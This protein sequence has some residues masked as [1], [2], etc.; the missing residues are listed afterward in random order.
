MNKTKRIL[1]ITITIFTVL[2]YFPLLGTVNIAQAALL[3]AGP[4][5]TLNGFPVWYQDNNGVAIQ[6]CLGINPDGTGLPDPLC[7][8]PGAGEE[9]NFDPLLPISF[10][11]NFPG[12]AFWWLAEIVENGVGQPDAEGGTGRLKFRYA[13]E[14]AFTVENPTPNE[15]ILFLRVNLM[16]ISHLVPGANYLVTHPFGQFTVHAGDALLPDGLPNPAAGVADDGKFLRIE[17]GAFAP[18]ITPLTAASILP[19]TETNIGSFLRM[20]NP[21]PPA[22]YLGDG[23][24]IGTITSGPNGNFLEIAGPN[25]DVGNIDGDGNPNKLHLID[26]WMVSGKIAVI[27]TVA[28]AIASVTPAEVAVDAAGNAPTNTVISANITDDLGARVTTID[29]SV[30]SNDF[31][32]VLNGIQEVP[33]TVSA[34]TGSGAFM[35]D[36]VANTLNF[37]ISY[38]GLQGGAETAAHI[39]GP[40]IAG[41]NAL[42][43]FDLPFGASKIGA[44][45]YPENLEADILAGRMYINIHTT[46]F[47]NGEIRGQILRTPNIQNMIM[48]AGT[49]TNGTW[50]IIIPSIPGLGTYILPISTSDGS[51]VTNFVFELSAVNPAPI[52]NADTATIGVN[53]GETAT[54]DVLA[55]DT[56]SNGNLPLSL[57]SVQNISAGTATINGNRV[58]ITTPNNVFAGEITAQYTVADSLGATS[59]GNITVTVVRSVFTTITVT[60]NP[61]T[62]PLSGNRQLNA[63][64]KDQFG[65]P[66]SSQPAITW[67]SSNNQVATVSGTGLVNGAALG[68]TQITAASGA[69][70]AV[71]NV[72]VTSGPVCETTADFDLSGAISN[73]EILNHVRAWK[74]GTVLNLEI[75]NAIRFWKTGTGC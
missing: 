26:R 74:A 38:S 7:V 57:V 52:A 32:T 19:A 48:N 65:T 14:A 24:A 30:L 36:T 37:N 15:Q 25:I 12:E 1:S 55:N 16:P 8:L 4:I 40:A 72:T 47:P 49:V 23:L 18:P 43:V 10:P 64:A 20:V 34:G 35:I 39:H 60:P 6:L 27:D 21:A 28:P 17:D 68:N 67:T 3:Q 33:A 69:I 73:L 56:D 22:G 42:P 9:P 45:N 31:T 54:L 58:I 63:I 41:V 70:S 71:V 44:W 29:L 53:I 59:N 50:S 46:L 61:L 13:L 51:N 5:S 2:S 75:L 66:L 11:S 62:V